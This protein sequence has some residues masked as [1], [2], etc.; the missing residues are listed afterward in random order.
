[1][2]SRRSQFLSI[3]LILFVTFS[4]DAAPK[5][6]KRAAPRKKAAPAAPLPTAVG[7]TL[8]ERLASLVNSSTARSADT[9][10]QIVEVESGRVVAQ[11]NPNMPL[12]PASNMKLFTTAAAIDMLKPTFE[13]TTGV[14]ARGNVDAT[15]TLEGDLKFVGRGDP[16][17][18]GRFHDGQA[19]AVIQEWAQD[20]MAAGIKNV[21]GDFIFE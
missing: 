12:A 18:G 20:L 2:T 6:K 7:A 19:T 1:M 8:E 11:R 14:F 4:A 17:I 13:V 15:G 9:S 10:I 16:T 21:H 5:K 3:L